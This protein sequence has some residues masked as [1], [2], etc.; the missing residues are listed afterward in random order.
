L[1]AVKT[2]L[3]LEYRKTAITNRYVEVT[4]V[5]FVLLIDVKIN[6]I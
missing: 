6:N 2:A 3:G 1:L 4:A 5:G